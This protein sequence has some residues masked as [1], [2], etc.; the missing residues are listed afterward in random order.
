MLHVENVI[1]LYFMWYISQSTH[2]NL[3]YEADQ[4]RVGEYALT[5]LVY[6]YEV[7]FILM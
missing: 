5:S 3:K 7:C 2:K 6:L 1:Y 4:Q